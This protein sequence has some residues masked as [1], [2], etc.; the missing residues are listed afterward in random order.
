MHTL[1]T[2][3]LQDNVNNLPI[4]T[5]DY[6]KFANSVERLQLE[7]NSLRRELEASIYTRDPLTGAI[8]S[9][10]MLPVLRE[11]YDL[12]KQ[13]KLN[14]A[15]IMVDLD[16]FK[17]INDTHGHASGD[18]VLANTARYLMHSVRGYDKVFRYGGEEFLICLTNVDPITAYDKTEELRKGLA[19]L[20][21]DIGNGKN[22]NITASFGI[23]MIDNNLTLEENMDRADKAMYNAKNAGRN[24]VVILEPGQG[25]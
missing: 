19:A 6:D 11:L 23:M 15:L 21:I 7:I 17:Q 3:L 24:C 1:A 16:K 20:K 14:C 13:R 10:D 4:S 12:N 9:T 25:R 22:I 18:D 5:Y 2:Q 8:N